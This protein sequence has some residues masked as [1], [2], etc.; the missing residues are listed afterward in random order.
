MEQ[1]SIV[2]KRSR[3]VPILIAL[4]EAMCD[5]RY[6]VEHSGNTPGADTLIILNGPHPNVFRQLL[7]ESQAQRTRSWYV[8]MFQLPLLPERVLAR[9]RVSDIS[10]RRVKGSCPCPV[11]LSSSS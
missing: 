2:R 8:F 9:K 3:L 1:I 5:P 11:Y 7:R 4:I 10:R 6:G